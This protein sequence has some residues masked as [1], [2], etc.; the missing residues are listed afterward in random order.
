[1][2]KPTF[3][4]QAQQVREWFDLVVNGYITE[5]LRQL[6]NIPANL[7]KGGCAVALAMTAFSA[8]NL[9][10]F[11]ITSKKLDPKNTTY[12]VVTFVCKRMKDLSGK[13]WY[14]SSDLAKG[15][16]KL[17]RH[18]FAHQ[19][20]P[21]SLTI[22]RGPSTGKLLDKAPDGSHTLSA[23]VLA[24]DVLAAIESLSKDVHDDN[25]R[26]LIELMFEKLKKLHEFNAGSSIKM[27][28][29]KYLDK[30]DIVV[31]EP[32]TETEK[33]DPGIPNEWITT[34]GGGKVPTIK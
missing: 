3:E 5:D 30:A 27:D 34:S 2:S 21:G 33:L 14:R 1:M 25:K 15:L 8:M 24:G 10:G 29:D 7:E 19:F 11:L 18:G 26:D 32:A 28:P 20:L 9:L 22:A 17:F 31:P 4:E 6:M 16:V 12:S 23:D 13:D